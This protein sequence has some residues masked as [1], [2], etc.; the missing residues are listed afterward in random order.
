[1]N[2][3]KNKKLEQ[4]NKIL[5]KYLSISTAICIDV[6]RIG[7]YGEI[8]LAIDLAG[9]TVVGHCYSPTYI[10]TLE[11]CKTI[12]TIQ[13]YRAFLP[14]IEIIHSDF[15]SIFNNETFYECLASLNIRS[16]KGLR[17]KNQNQVVERLNRTIKDIIRT[18]ML[19]KRWQKKEE[20]D[21][22]YTQKFRA[23]QIAEIIKQSVEEYNQ[24]PHTA[25]FGLSPNHMEEA[26]F[27]KHQNKATAK[28]VTL[29]KNDQATK[30][31][32]PL[33]VD[34]QSPIAVDIRDYKK[35]VAEK[36]KGDW[37]QFFIEWKL[38]QEQQYKLVVNEIIKSVQESRAKYEN[39]YRQ[40]IEM[41]KQ[42]EFFYQ[43]ALQ[44]Q[45][46]KQEKELIKLKKQQAKKLPLR[47][48]IDPAEFYEILKM[49]EGKPFV[50]ERKTLALILLYLTG[51]RVSNLLVFNV[52][53]GKELFEKGQTKIKLRKGCE[54]RFNLVL[55][56]RARRLL[57]DYK[58]TFLTLCE[59]KLDNDPLF[60]SLSN[61]SI[62]MRSDNFEK[63][64]NKILEKA[65]IILKKNIRTHSFRAT[66]ITEL[67]TNNIAIDDVK[68]IIGHKSIESTLNYKRLRLSP[69]QRVHNTK[70]IE[71][72]KIKKNFKRLKCNNC[73]E[74]II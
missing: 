40:H 36:Y 33:W 32:V 38:D 41:Q 22:F 39:L 34:D 62:P 42:L 24:R 68:E 54:E 70:K 37:E 60:T 50:K 74:I 19:N 21:P 14:K 7:I 23:N 55:S 30:E 6:I 67:L 45:K 63:E 13:R 8:L 9:R 12:E 11:V 66:V 15:E 64:L 52:I 46:E 29:W 49:V 48:T 57:L 61:N 16:S 3:I 31:L 56:T 71:S 59:D 72:K 27:Q 65:S 53:N 17:K 25:L 44:V 43:Q 2:N 4:Q 69:R 18:K 73:Y 51:L 28:L 35:E 1:M 26:L 58:D 10:N 20:K 5:N 47:D